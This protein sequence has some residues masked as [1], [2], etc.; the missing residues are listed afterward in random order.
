MT[1]AN[2]QIS[3]SITGT[4]SSAHGL[5]TP[6]AALS[7]TFTDGLADST[8]YFSLQSAI[9]VGGINIID[10]SGSREDDLGN[11]ISLSVVNLVFVKNNGVVGA[12]G[13]MEVGNT[14]SFFKFFGGSTLGDIKLN[15]QGVFLWYESSGVSVVGGS[16]DRVRISGTAGDQFQLIIFGL[17]AP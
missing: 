9:S 7:Q 14:V 11:P 4:L 1:L 6:G 10:L 16:S 5:V 3:V 17:R 12:D 2:Q 8:A 15:P 13:R